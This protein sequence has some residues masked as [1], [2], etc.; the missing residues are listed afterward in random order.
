M[1]RKATQI[2]GELFFC[3]CF[4]EITHKNTHKYKKILEITQNTLYNK[5]RK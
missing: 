4:M 3:A 1:H 5:K 2:I